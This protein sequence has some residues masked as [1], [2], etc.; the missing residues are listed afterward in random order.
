MI[1]RE[2][3]ILKFRCCA[4]IA[5]CG[6]LALLASCGVSKDKHLTR[7][8]EFLQKRKFQEAVI[9]FRAADIDR[10]SAVGHW[11]LA[12]AYEHLEQFNEAFEE[13]RKT[14]ERAPENL[15]PKTKPG[16]NHLLVQP[17]MISE[18]EKILEEVF[19]RGGGRDCR[20]RRDCADFAGDQV[21]ERMVS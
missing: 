10:D 12:R 4:Q 5:L 15:D 16:N 11:G 21:F 14:A 17:A 20:H 18:T 1:L 19:A 13:L 2:C 6:L 7:G 3:P 9:E 8:E